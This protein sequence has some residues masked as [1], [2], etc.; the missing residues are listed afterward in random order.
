MVSALI[1]RVRLS[2]TDA[3]IVQGRSV[4]QSADDVVV[5]RIGDVTAGARPGPGSAR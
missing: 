5:S 4:L 3:K 2:R 1:R